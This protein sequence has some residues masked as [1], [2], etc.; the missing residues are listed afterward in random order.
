MS[1]QAP[2]AV[3]I[4]PMMD[5]TDRY[6]RFFARLLSKHTLL[7]TE[8]VNMNAVV[9]GD[10]PHLLRY[11][12]CEHPIALQLGGDDA[13]MLAAAA[14][15]G[16]E[17]FGYDEVNLNIGCPSERV[18]SGNFGACLMQTPE[19]VAK[20]VAAMKQ[21]VDVPITVKHRIGVDDLDGYEHMLRFV[22]IVAE[23]GCRRFSV[24]ARKAW[25]KGLSPKENR[26]IPPIRYED[27]YRLKQDRPELWVEIN[28]HIKTHTEMQQH[29]EHVDAVMIGR[30]AWDN[31]WL[32]A[33][34]DALFFG[35]EPRPLTRFDVVEAYLPFAEAELA[36][37]NRI[38]RLTKPLLALFGGEAG[39]RVWRRALTEGAH[40]KGDTIQVITDALALLHDA[41]GAAERRHAV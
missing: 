36:R 14:K 21:A 37:G 12:E 24:H 2:A 31:P 19:V 3:S 8:M 40:S 27:V 26:N 17:E 13:N 38:Q 10:R 11:H 18:Q 20:A 41:Q 9:H 39:A 1:E 33:D 25:L 29:L 15:V 28:G 5:R 35:A 30:A 7:Y 16:V 4:A 23:A 32:F 6:Y 34:V 22:D